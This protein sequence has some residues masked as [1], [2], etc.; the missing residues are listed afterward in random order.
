MEAGRRLW[1]QSVVLGQ[2]AGAPG[3]VQPLHAVGRECG[4]GAVD[5][6]EGILD[7]GLLVVLFDELRRGDSSERPP[8]AWGVAPSGGCL[9]AR[10]SPCWRLVA[11]GELGWAVPGRSGHR[12]PGASGPAVV[13]WPGLTTQKR[14]LLQCRLDGQPR[15]DCGQRQGGCHLPQGTTYQSICT[16]E[17]DGD[18]CFFATQGLSLPGLA[19]PYLG[20]MRLPW[21]APSP[22][23]DASLFPPTW[24]GVLAEGDTWTVCLSSPLFSLS[25]SPLPA[26]G[27]WTLGPPLL[28]TAR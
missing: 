6:E 28:P 12:L 19:S 14:R 17:S 18:K 9:E 4:G 27:S 16:K 2:L 24:P 5:F 26:A 3:W 7:M 21:P 11:T 23:G 10:D 22:P 25:L 15:R 1:T 13:R 20:A 8:L